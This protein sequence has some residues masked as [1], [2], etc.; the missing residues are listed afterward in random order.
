MRTISAARQ[1]CSI[2]AAYRALATRMSAMPDVSETSLRLSI[3][4]F[5]LIDNS[6]ALNEAKSGL[7]DGISTREW[8]M[9]A[10]CSV[11]WHEEC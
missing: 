8:W 9:S 2:P 6:V 11:F 1:N 4:R 10:P 7:P 3:R 5:R